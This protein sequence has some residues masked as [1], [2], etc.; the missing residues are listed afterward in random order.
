MNA[1]VRVICFML[2]LLAFSLRATGAGGDWPQSIP[3]LQAAIEKVL[4]ET[5]TPGAAIAIVSSNQAEWVA[6]IGK[7]D[8]ATGQPVTT[9]NLFRLGSISK[10]FVAIAAL[11][12]QEEGKLKLSDTVKQWVPDVAFVN[13]WEATHPLRLVHLLEQTSGFD[14]MHLREFALNDRTPV[15]LKDALADDVACR[16]CRWPPGTRM[17]YCNAAP[18]VLAPR[19]EKPSPQ[20]FA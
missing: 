6:G 12:L 18:A 14:D 16:V 10:T 7:A 15:S 20:R 13:P 19:V 11:Q 8:V 3:Q 5:R 1:A 9:N 2:L 17:S 4:K